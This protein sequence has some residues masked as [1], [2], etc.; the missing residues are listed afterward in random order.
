MLIEASRILI[1]NRIKNVYKVL[2]DKSMELIKIKQ[3]Q[4]NN[5]KIEFN[6]QFNMKTL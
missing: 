1:N 2:D 4:A 3:D 5:S 6:Q